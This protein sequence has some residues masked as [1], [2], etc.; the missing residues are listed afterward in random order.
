MGDSIVFDPDTT[1]VWDGAIESCFE[2]ECEAAEDMI[3]GLSTTS[4]AAA[5][6]PD[7]RLG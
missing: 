7:L 1:N 6:F 5:S 2:A 3:S 4:I